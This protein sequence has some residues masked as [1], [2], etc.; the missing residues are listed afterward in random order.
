MVAVVLVSLAA[1]AG[2]FSYDHVRL[3][4][5]TGGDFVEATVGEPRYV[6]PVLAS[7]NDLDLD[8][9]QLIFSGLM[10]VD[11]KGVAQL[12]LAE[13]FVKSEDGKTY[14]FKL[15]PGVTWHDGIAFTSKDVALTINAI[16][17]PA[18]QSPHAL[19]FKGVTV[20]APDDLT[21]VFTLTDA[22][23]TFLSALTVG[24]LP[25]HLWID[26]AGSD[27][28]RAQLNV[29]PIGTG[30][31]KFKSFIQDKKGTIH[32]YSLTRNEAY[33]GTRA[34]LDTVTFQAYSSFAEAS[35]ALAKRKVSAVSFLPAENEPLVAESGESI[36]HRFRL[37]QY[38]A[39]FFNLETTKQFSADVRKALALAIDR[40][41][42]LSEALGNRNV[43]AY[44]PI[45]PAFAAFTPDVPKYSFDREAAAKM[46]DTA[47]WVAGADGKRA[48][49]GVPL[50]FTLTTT[51]TRDV[52][53]VA[54][55]LKE[56]WEAI[57]VT[58]EV[59]S[60]NHQ[61]ISKE[62]IKTKDYEVLLYGE[63]IGIDGDLLPFWHSTQAEPGGLNL[64]RWK[65]KDADVLLQKAREFPTQEGRTDALQKFQSILMAD[66]PAIFLY[67]P[68]YPYAT[69]R[70]I[71]GVETG[72]LFSP[73]NRFAGVTGWYVETALSWQ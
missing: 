42:L 27:A 5:S 64:S 19:D 11:G 58:V 8:L 22:S 6:N 69:L 15:R 32:N 29:K 66:L 28:P 61:L 72:I 21:V 67:S 9:V 47:G 46:L 45:L 65:N 71:K 31:F 41:R 17:N 23:P 7:D 59:A 14:T 73:A 1:M 51:E 49:K 3:V 37:P 60:V 38:T 36:V 62:K 18:W 43:A 10:Q 48:K 12:D 25:E 4:P 13:S 52:A 57:G 39:I 70:S 33:Y 30:P 44:G 50:K 68:T 54:A 2:K 20:E 24:I 55:I 63:I 34:R 56:D 40:D 53:A 16:K 35:D 26:V